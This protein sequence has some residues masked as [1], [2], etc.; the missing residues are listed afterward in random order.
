MLSRIARH[1]LHLVI[2]ALAATFA[3]LASLSMRGALSPLTDRDVCSC[4][5]EPYPAKCVNLCDFG[6]K[7]VVDGVE[8]CV[9]GCEWFGS[10]GSIPTRANFHEYYSDPDCFTELS[11][12]CQEAL[13]TAWAVEMINCC[14]Q[15]DWDTLGC[16]F[17]EQGDIDCDDL[18]E[19]ITQM[20]DLKYSEECDEHLT[21]EEILKLVCCFLAHCAGSAGGWTDYCENL[22]ELQDCINEI[23][24]RDEYEY[25][26]I[27]GSEWEEFLEDCS[28]CCCVETAAASGIWYS[29][30]GDFEC[31]LNGDMEI[32][33]DDIKEFLDRAAKC[34]RRK[35]NRELNGDDVAE[36]ICTFIANCPL[37]FDCSDLQDLLDCA[38]EWLEASLTQAQ[39]EQ[40][41]QC[42]DEECHAEL[43]HDI[44]P[45]VEDDP[46]TP[47]NEDLQYYNG[48]VSGVGFKCDLNCDGEVDCED[49]QEFIRLSEACN[50]GGFT[51]GNE[52]QE[53][54]Q[55]ICKFMEECEN[56]ELCDSLPLC[57]EAIFEEHLGLE[58]GQVNQADVDWLTDPENCEALCLVGIPPWAYNGD[59]I[60]AWGCDTP[61]TCVAGEDSGVNP[62]G[63]QTEELWMVSVPV[64]GQ[65]YPLMLEYNSNTAYDG[66]NAVGMGMT[67]SPFR[68]VRYDDQ[69]EVF[70]QDGNA[71]GSI[72]QTEVEPHPT[73]SNWKLHGPNSEELDRTTAD[74]FMD[75]LTYSV[76][77]ITDP[78]RTIRDFYREPESGE[79]VEA[80]DDALIGLPLQT[81]DAHGNVQTYTYVIYPRDNTLGGPATVARPSVLKF[82]TADDDPSTDRP[83]AEMRFRWV[84]AGDANVVGRVR[85]ITVLRYDGSTPVITHR[86]MF[87]YMGDN[88]TFSTDIGTAG[89]LVQVVVSELVD[90]DLSAPSSATGYRSRVTQF[91]YFGGPSP[92]G[93][94]TGLGT[95]AGSAHQL[96]MVIQPEQIEYAAQKHFQTIGSGGSV[97]GYA[98]QLLRLADDD[99]AFMNDPGI[100]SEPIVVSKMAAKVISEYDNTSGKVKTQFIQSSCGC[101]GGSTQGLKR[102]FT[103]FEYGGP[104]TTDWTM[105]IKEFI[106]DGIGGYDLHRVL[107]LDWTILPTS[108]NEKTM[109]FL[110][111]R[112]IWVDTNEDDDI[113]GGEPLWVTH[114]DYDA[115]RNVTAQYTP[116][117]MNT[118][119]AGLSSAATYSAKSGAGLIHTY[120]YTGENRLTTTS[121]KEGTSGTAIKLSTITYDSTRKWLPIKIERFRTD[122]NPS[123]ADNI[124]VTEFAYG[125]H[126]AGSTTTDIAWVETEVEA[127]LVAENGPGGTYL[128][129]ELFDAKGRNTYSIGADK[130]ITKRTHDASTGL[131]LTVTRNAGNDLSSPYHGLTTSGFGRST[132]GGSLTT[133]YVR[134]ILGRVIERISPGLISTYTMREM[135]EWSQ[136]PGITYYAEV[137]LPHLISTANDTYDGP[138]AITWYDAD[139]HVIGSMDHTVGPDD[140]TFDSG[141]LTD[142][143]EA[144]GTPIALSSVSHHLS[145]LVE[146]R[147][148]WHDV[149]NDESYTSTFEYDALG[150]VATTIDPL[151]T[152]TVNTYDVLDRVISVQVGTSAGNLVTVAQYFYDSG[153]TATP[154]T[155]NGN[156]TL[157]R[158]HVDSSSGND[159]DTIYTY[160]WRD[161]LQL[162]EN[163]LAP[164][165]WVEY[166]NLDR[167]TQEA[168]FSVAPTG[169]D[170]SAE[171]SSRGLYKKTQYSQR[172]LVYAQSIA[173]DPTV[174]VGSMTF[175]VTHRWFDQPGRAVGSWSPNG[176]MTKS[177]FDGLGRPSVVYVSDRRDDALPGASGNH[178]DVYTA[179][180]FVANVTG[181]VVLEQRNYRYIDGSTPGSHAG[182]LDLVTSRRRS[183]GIADTVTGALSSLTSS[184]SII[185][186]TATF[187]DGADRVIRS[188][189][190]GT[191]QA[192]FNHGGPA[193]T[194]NQASPPD[195]NSGGDQLV[196]ETAYNA[197]GLVDTSTDP[198]GQVTAYFY[199]D[200]NRTI[201]V[202]ENFDDATVTWDVGDGCWEVG[203][204]DDSELDVDR[205][206]TFVY[207]GGSNVIKQ[208]AHFPVSGTTEDRQVTLY[209]YG[210]TTGQSPA[211]T[212]YH[213]GLLRSV[214]YPD[215]EAGN[216]D[217]VLYAYNRLGETL[218]MVDQNGS[219]HT[220]ARDD[221]GRVTQDEGVKPGSGPG[222]DIDDTFDTITIA[223]D[224]FGRTDT[225]K[226]LKKSD[227]SVV[228]AIKFEYTKLWQI[229]NVWQDPDSDVTTSGGGASPKVAYTY[230]DDV[231]NS[232]GG[233][234]SRLDEMTYPGGEVIE[235]RYGTAATS[236]E[237]ISRLQSLRENIPGTGAILQVRY[238]YLGL[239]MPATVDYAVPDIQLDFQPQH[240]GTRT[241]GQY[242]GFDR[243]GRVIKQAWVDGAY[244][245]HGSSGS[246]PN[247]PPIVETT[248]SYDKASNRTKMLDGRPGALFA[249]RDMVYTYDGLHRL[250][251]A[252]RGVDGGSFTPAPGSEKWN[253]DMLGN[254]SKFLTDGNGD[255][256]YLDSNE[257]TRR[258][259]NDVN[260][261]TGVDLDGNGSTDIT[262]TFDHAGNLREQPAGLVTNSHRYT[263]DLWNR[264]VK[265]EIFK[266]S[267][268][269]TVGEYQYYGTHW[270]SIKRADTD[271][272]VTLD[273]QREQYYSAGWQLVE[274]RVYDSW[275]SGSPGSVDRT[276]QYL[277]GGRYID[278]IVWHRE[279]VNNDGDFT[280]AGDRRW[281]HCTDAQFSTVALV[282]D[283]AVLAERVRYDAYGRAAHFH[284][285]DN[286]GDRDFDAT[287]RTAL[288]NLI[289]SGSVPIT[290]GSYDVAMDL[291][292]DGDVDST[293][294]SIMGTGYTAALGLGA[295]SSGTVGNTIGWDGYVFSAEVPGA[296]GGGMYHVR[297]R[298]YEA[299]LGRWVERDPAG[300]VDGMGLYE[301]VGGAPMFRLDSMGLFQDPGGVRLQERRM[302]DELRR[303]IRQQELAKKHASHGANECCEELTLVVDFD[304]GIDLFR[305]LGTIVY[306]NS[307]KAGLEWLAIRAENLTQGRC[308]CIKTLIIAG[309]SGNCGTLS[310]GD[311]VT[312]EDLSL[313][314]T[315]NESQLDSVT[316]RQLSQLRRVIHHLC[317]DAT[318]ELLQCDLGVDF[319]VEFWRLINDDGTNRSVIVYEGEAH[320]VYGSTTGEGRQVVDRQ[321]VDGL[322]SCCDPEQ[323]Q[324]RKPKEPEPKNPNGG[325][326]HEN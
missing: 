182:M 142:W 187:F 155:G 240:N 263:H 308:A 235:Y 242:A 225:V 194:V 80:I 84:Y 73:G 22:E 143:D 253:L 7:V 188:V 282:D 1:R 118:Y 234:F 252:Q 67:A 116:E 288:S 215:T 24:A 301:Y 152:Y 257:E 185:T 160:D 103:H 121:V 216:E 199:D 186:Y 325:N 212:L 170:E 95:F 12:E 30:C 39:A 303:R 17:D 68:F 15:W 322:T 151:G 158:Q 183:H 173:I 16:N 309:H 122:D 147:T 85:E 96:K 140:Y 239:S 259:H 61:G 102:A 63:H 176:P 272:D 244:T 317:P 127:E 53:I 81:T 318:V 137:T 275:S 106:D 94:G 40:I 86:V 50:E 10:T 274:E 290:S 100:G 214:E 59:P 6:L 249:D 117:A 267:V 89:D 256:D 112:A 203:G 27:T 113:D 211:S 195:W 268:W 305:P 192:G 45:L 310:I 315:Q 202:A 306:R 278:D 62:Y 157:V 78:G 319:G 320:F 124:E 189:N 254:W 11:P 71:K 98:G 136:R 41:A 25:T 171:R 266:G 92:G 51:P 207:N 293:D 20:E 101:G 90:R 224:G 5:E 277:W 26:S 246:V 76:W 3:V 108:G 141:V 145:G 273:E 167:V 229:A 133:E 179:A 4:A 111:N 262:L 204:I 131:V 326:P 125:F 245:T 31:D 323:S 156:L 296:S 219:Q 65:D 38:C 144:G 110:V 107:L 270:R 313:M 165:R 48:D 302:L 307:R 311:I 74:F 197:R 232:N 115:D 295:L 236:H 70:A 174:A 271:N 99:V 33:C 128:S 177:T 159:R 55:L 280:D 276:F 226:T 64:N 200:L 120:A 198:T 2:V 321:F 54:L 206:T 138:V 32:D 172:G 35:E 251:E 126:T 286:D 69:A 132:D 129:Y 209:T 91:R 284:P 260:E 297:F 46:E 163:P 87:T 42:L 135:R 227:N 291:D 23:F 218:T 283:A 19:F 82:W 294:L 247:I 196:S 255:G 190:Y 75:G 154:G 279:D 83:D 287:D 77:R 123:G 258:S 191:N 210:V 168:V 66:S 243:F 281:W 97:A 175:L 119:S 47:E 285:Y 289:A 230:D 231:I 316:R 228:N 28:E 130:A 148:A 164:H 184:R 105:R 88:A 178:A 93:S 205:V 324:T 21:R 298:W 221:L 265:V 304:P 34:T 162:V 193:P 166:D 150:R 261:L 233:N 181:D 60:C 269:N 250:Q 58:H 134:D 57:M 9:P 29:D 56:E 153:G 18:K 237:R 37:A 79:T 114:T 169:I 8:F 300:Y 52:R 104:P 222:A 264:L 312:K 220:Y 109:P 314:R 14:D 44:D 161:R 238:S 241:A 149:A 248:Y 213:N 43:C 201:A 217:T 139:D 13:I 292:R 36:L 146:S 180:T 223:Y 49:L 299:G 72:F 208:V